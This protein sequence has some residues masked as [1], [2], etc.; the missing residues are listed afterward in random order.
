MAKT[1]QNAERLHANFYHAFIDDQK[2]E[3]LSSD[4]LD[5]ADRLDNALIDRLHALEPSHE[6]IDIELP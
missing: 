1:Y 2:F 4:I 5:L 3:T 6:I